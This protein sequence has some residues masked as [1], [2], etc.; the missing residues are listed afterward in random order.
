MRYLKTMALTVLLGSGAWAGIT[1]Q[2]DNT[3]APSQSMP[4]Q[5]QY[6]LE[7]Y[8]GD[9]ANTT[10]KEEGFHSSTGYSRTKN[11]D[12]TFTTTGDLN[13]SNNRDMEEFFKY[14]SQSNNAMRVINALGNRNEQAR[15]RYEID[16]KK[17][18]NDYLYTMYS[19]SNETNYTRRSDA[20]REFMVNHTVSGKTIKCYVKRELVP[21]YFCP[22][23]GMN[24]TLYGGDPADESTEVKRACDE[25]CVTP[26]LGCR[27]ADTG[28]ADVVSSGDVVTYA[29]GDTGSTSLTFHLNE[30]L[31]FTNLRYRIHARKNPSVSW[32]QFKAA[33]VSLPY[34][35]EYTDR[36]NVRKTAVSRYP[37]FID[38]NES[39][40]LVGAMP[41]AKEVVLTFMTPEFDASGS[42]AEKSLGDYLSDIRVDGFEVH[43]ASSEYYFCS[44][45]QIVTDVSTQ[46]KT[47]KIY[48]ISGANGSFKVCVKASGVKGPEP[49]YHAFYSRERCEQACVRRE[50]CMP[51]FAHYT[52]S[53]I[54]SPQAYRISIGCADTPGNAA[55][56]PALCEQLIGSEQMPMQ[57]AVYSP[58]RTARYTV[59][60]GAELPD[61][62]RPKLDLDAERVAAASGNYEAAFTEEMKDVAYDNMIKHGTFNYVEKTIAEGTPHEYAYSRQVVPNA[63]PYKPSKISVQ[64]LV[65]P[66]SDE[67]DRM[68][69]RFFVVARYEVIYQPISGVFMTDD[70]YSTS[71]AE[72]NRPYF[73]D[74]M[75]AS[76][77]P[78]G[79]YKPFYLVEYA[80]IQDN[81]VTSAEWRLNM[82]HRKARYVRYDA[83]GDALVTAGSEPLTAAKTEPFSKALNWKTL[84]VSDDLFEDFTT[85]AR[86]VMFARQ[87][88]EGDTALPTKRWAG[89]RDVT[90]GSLGR[91]RLYGFYARSSM[92]QR[93]AVDR[94]LKS[95]EEDAEKYLFYDSVRFRSL[96]NKIK[97]DGIM[98]ASPVRIFLKG[99]P[100][101]MDASAILSPRPEDEGKDAVMFMFLYKDN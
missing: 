93:T 77:L 65:K 85:G 12:G 84:D 8:A 63:S 79:G 14:R 5:G 68:Q 32:E 78:T 52:F 47:G 66:R 48:N 71:Y 44:M 39:E 72:E 19:D 67:Y 11:P 2:Q 45:D 61:V 89:A 25:V 56:S 96:P 20:M 46:C 75:L 51:T 90:A 99:S 28:E 4:T 81:N 87:E 34:R 55:C 76:L 60:G 100:S 10:Q 31:R 26:T 13:L 38:D 74:E 3:Q 69:Y 50:E 29:A 42:Y 16:A 70:S 49:T 7:E 35:L 88:T 95:D 1:L 24:Q 54:T 59:V 58:T 33:P 57:E 98:D 36:A 23:P 41:D 92:D 97:G 64:W 6:T 40:V 9:D 94:I 21:K 43:Y 86:G 82:Q 22:L 15:D 91:I 62:R 101:S 27:G 37:V 30:K 53:Q 17:L 83:A 80:Y 18:T 73:K